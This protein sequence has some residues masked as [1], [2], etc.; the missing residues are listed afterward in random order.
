VIIPGSAYLALVAVLGVAG[1]AKLRDM[2]EFAGAVGGYRVIPPGWAAAVAWLVVAAELTGAVLLGIPPA[3]RWG[4]VLAMAL[5]AAFTAAMATV[6]RRGLRIRCG[7]LHSRGG[8][9]VGTGTVT[10][11]ALLFV[12][13]ATAA[14][15]PAPFSPAQLPVAALLLAAVFLIAWLAGRAGRGDAQDEPPPT[16]PAVGAQAFVG[17][18]VATLSEGSDLV[19]FGFIS[20]LCDLCTAMLPEF[21]AVARRER[22]VL[23]SSGDRDADAGHLAS[24]GIG[25]PLVTHP[26]VFEANDIPWPPFAVITTGTGTVL[27]AGSTP[28]PDSLATLLARA[29]DP[30]QAAGR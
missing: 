3:R 19:V 9:L 5:F 22:V 14:A 8:E 2:R 18:P 23:V 20:P 17:V 7:C 16:G 4:A 12:L 21:A 13:A 15:D 28:H 30:R 1:L 10:R 27:A 6:L 25:L 26:D 11:S 29:A 24:H